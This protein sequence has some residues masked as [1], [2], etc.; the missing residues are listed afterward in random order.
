MQTDKQEDI[1]QNILDNTN[2]SIT[3]NGRDYL[4][5]IKKQKNKDYC[6]LFLTDCSDKFWIEKMDIEYC[7]QLKEEM[8]VKT[9]T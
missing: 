6:T 1:L 3:H 8:N 9:K 4:V 5:L 2:C 7:E